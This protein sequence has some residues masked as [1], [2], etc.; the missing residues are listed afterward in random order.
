[1]SLGRRIR[2]EDIVYPEDEYELTE[3]GRI[4]LQYQRKPKYHDGNT[5][6]WIHEEN[7]ER[8]RTHALQSQEGVRGILLPILDSAKMWFIVVITGLAI[9]F[10]GAWLDVLVK[11]YALHVFEIFN[12]ILRE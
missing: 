10:A 11:W 5:I 9:G 4:P 6:D 12:L 8:E 2:Q 1:M 7:L 3:D